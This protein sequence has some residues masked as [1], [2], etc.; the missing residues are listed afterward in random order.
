ME[1]LTGGGIIYLKNCRFIEFEA[2]QNNM[3]LH[4][5]SNVRLIAVVTF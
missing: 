4:A 2:I 1:G 5:S 3:Q